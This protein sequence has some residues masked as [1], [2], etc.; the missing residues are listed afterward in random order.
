MRNVLCEFPEPD[1]STC[2]LNTGIKLQKMTTLNTGM[3]VYVKKHNWDSFK[4]WV[5]L[6]NSETCNF[7]NFKQI[8]G[9]DAFLSITQK[10][11]L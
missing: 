7:F 5:R 10:L 6:K 11:T 3:F 4:S 8:L 1:K 2:P 9:R